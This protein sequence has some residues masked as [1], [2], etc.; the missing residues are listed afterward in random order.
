M[1]GSIEK[2][3]DNSTSEEDIITYYEANKTDVLEQ[4]KDY[5]QNPSKT[6]SYLYHICFFF[7]KYIEFCIANNQACACDM[8][9]IVLTVHLQE[10]YSQILSFNFILVFIRLCSSFI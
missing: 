5:Y 8:P 10:L 6:N 1:T 2:F 9:E 4:K 7:L 3:S